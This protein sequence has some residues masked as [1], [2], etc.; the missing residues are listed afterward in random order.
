MEQVFH[1]LCL[2]QWMAD[3]GDF[4]WVDSKRPISNYV[5]ILGRIL[6]GFDEKPTPQP[7]QEKLDHQMLLEVQQWHHQGFLRPPPPGTFI[8]QLFPCSWR[9]TPWDWPPTPSC[10]LPVSSEQLPCPFKKIKIN[11]IFRIYLIYN[12]NT[13]IIISTTGY[14]NIIGVPP[15]TKATQQ[16]QNSS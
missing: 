9:S 4:E 2:K 6:H 16:Q 15:S 13:I 8:M 14:P 11:A 5:L 10:A 7:Q 12:N 1:L 3:N